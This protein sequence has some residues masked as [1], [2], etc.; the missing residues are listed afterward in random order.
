MIYITIAGLVCGLLTCFVL[1]GFPD[2]RK[3]PNWFL[4]IAVLGLSH[5]LLM[6]YLNDSGKVLDFPHLIRTG[7]LS[8]Y[9]VFPFL[10]LFYRGVFESENY[11]RKSYFLLLLP[12]A[13]YLID[14]SAFF[15]LTG[16]EKVA[17]FT[18]KVGDSNALFLVDEGLFKLK[19]FHFIF[20]TLWGSIFLILIGQILLRFKKE[21][22]N[23]SSK[24]DYT[25][26]KKLVH[27]WI[28]LIALLMV[29]AVFN[30]LMPFQTY[31]VTFIIISLS[32]T[33]IFISLNLFI[34]PR[35]LYGFY[36]EFEK[37]SISSTEGF[38][39]K[40]DTE[41][42][43]FAKKEEDELFQKLNDF[44]LHNKGYLTLGYSIHK[45]A[46]EV[47]IP[48]YRIS[49]IINK[50]SNQNFSNWI[51][52]Y[53]VQHFIGLVKKGEAEKYTLDSIA[54]DCGFSS[55][56]TLINAFKKEKGM[57][58]GSYLRSQLAGK[59]P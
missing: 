5:S 56:T 23:S 32:I 7:H 42:Q 8:V 20:R 4:G 57:T 17:V 54:Q 16:E 29:P 36:W 45:L 18:S 27:L 31:T 41:S 35:L 11:W 19:N 6:A 22:Q 26:F 2:S 43:A 50:S 49:Y 34:Y 38:S 47:K 44:V 9:L 37:I 10:Y 39:P 21:F 58:P 52:S 28:C 24:G 51:N 12:L 55:R 14:F 40:H 13:L 33:L 46:E 25:L 48:A 30:L 3:S 59:K 15:I 1:L 53:R